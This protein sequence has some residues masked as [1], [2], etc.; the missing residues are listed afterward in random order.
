MHKFNIFRRKRRGIY[1]KRLKYPSYSILFYQNFEN[2]AM[3]LKKWDA[4][5]PRFSM[6]YKFSTSN[7]MYISVAQGFR[8]PVLD[9]MSRTGK[10]KGGFK[11]ANPDLNPEL[12][13]SYE[14]GI[15]LRFLKNLLFNGS[16]FYSIG[17]DFMYYTSTG[18]SVNMGY[19][20]APILK[21]QNIGK[22]EI[23]GVE[24]ELKYEFKENLIT[25]VNYT[26]TQ[27]QIIEH[28]ITDAR[29]DSSLTGKFLTDI[30]N[31]KFSSG[32]TLRN[33]FANTSLLFKYYGQTWIN[34]WNTVDTE[35][36]KTD[37][38]PEYYTFNIRIEKE[39][40]SKFSI[41][42]S[43][44][45]ILNKIYVD[46]NLEQCPGRFATGSVRYKFD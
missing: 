20:L 18:D 1:P 22:V 41:S 38:F 12:I 10:K 2:N 39:L 43:I 36:F 46:G 15:D 25:F 3:P 44:E 19:K 42:L 31:H 37:K 11:V 17:R 26:Y 4:F 6:Q 29:V 24:L 5:C 35:Y 45:N 33:K 32:I 8:A 34:D 30:P 14:T 23:K 28:N 40:F 21:M 7:R 27:A 13:T 16:V 9:D